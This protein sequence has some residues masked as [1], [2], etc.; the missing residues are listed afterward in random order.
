MSK[1]LNADYTT[2]LLRRI[3]TGHRPTRTQVGELT[4][5]GYLTKPGTLTPK[6][7]RLINHK[8]GN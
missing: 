3:A 8:E 6:A 2:Q 5:D 4:R 7:I 1:P